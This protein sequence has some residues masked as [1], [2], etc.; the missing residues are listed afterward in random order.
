MRAPSRL[1]DDRSGRESLKDL[2]LEACGS[3]EGVA[4]HPECLDRH[5]V[6]LVPHRVTCDIGNL[7]DKRSDF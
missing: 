3:E 6:A 7:V 2:Q 4:G 5:V 1:I